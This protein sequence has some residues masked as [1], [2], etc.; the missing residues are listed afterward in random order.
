MVFILFFVA[1][2]VWLWVF[3]Y[4]LQKLSAYF[5]VEPDPIEETLLYQVDAYKCSANI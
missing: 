3:V 4:G 5:Q 1:F 2:A